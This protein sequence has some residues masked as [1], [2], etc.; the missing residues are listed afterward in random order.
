MKYSYISLLFLFFHFSSLLILSSCYIYENNCIKFQFH[1]KNGQILQQFDKLTQK[2]LLILNEK[3]YQDNHHKSIDHQDQTTTTSTISEPLWEISFVDNFGEILI[4]NI[5]YI[6]SYNLLHNPENT[7]EII[8]KNITIERNKI[9]TIVDVK[10]E[11]QLPENSSIASFLFFVD[12][13]DGSP[14]GIW[15]TR[16]SI[17]YTIG[18]MD[19]GELFFPS[20]FGT[21]YVDPVISAGSG[22]NSLYPGSYAAMQYM[23]LGA[24]SSPVAGYF[25]AHDSHGTPKLLEYSTSIAS[26]RNTIHLSSFHDEQNSFLHSINPKVSLST[27]DLESIQELRTSDSGTPIIS[28][29]RITI[30]P[31][32]AGVALSVPSSWQSSYSL[33]LGIVRD[34][35]SAENRPMWFEAAQI[36]REWV[37]ASAEWTK[38]GPLSTRTNSPPLPSWYRQNHIWINSHWQCHDIFNETGGDPNF[39]V[40]NTKSIAKLFDQKSLALHWYEWQQGPD[41]TPEGRYKFDTH[42]PDYFPPR[43][44]FYE[45]V[46]SLL[47]EDGVFTF[48]YINGR[49]FDINSDSY[50]QENGQQYCAKKTSEKIIHDIDSVNNL[51]SYIETYGSDATFCVANPI[52][53]YWQQKVSEV[54]DELV[55]KYQVS[56]VYIDQIGI[57]YVRYF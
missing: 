41:P 1:E 31:E 49:I 50:L 54:V 28:Y 14:L 56:G 18:S 19:D 25:A 22:I 7:L 11:L 40:E 39:I 26:T 24:K 8:W 46:A 57:F 34:V 3:K 27:D 45:T 47:K 35:S 30:Y 21:T 36:Y 20:G 48:P 13:V 33:A 29:L 43:P 42:Y 5:D 10:I 4:T 51:E 32:N 15:Q 38:S 53:P 37:L 9:W 52:T 16:I 55:N 6:V 23:S 44:N 17:P 12:M 2:N